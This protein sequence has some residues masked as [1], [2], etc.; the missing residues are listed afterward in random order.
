VIF[1]SFER[2]RQMPL[3]LSCVLIGFFIWLA[4]N[5]PTFVG[6]WHYPNQPGAWS[7][8]HLSK[9]SSWSLLVIMTFTIVASLKHI[10]AKIHV[11]EA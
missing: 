6:V 10:K 9:W 7:L 1:R 11:P 4:E 5:P 8:V 3:L 2:D